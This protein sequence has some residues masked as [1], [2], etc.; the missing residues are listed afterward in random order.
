MNAPGVD[1][2]AI[3]GEVVDLAGVRFRQAGDFTAYE[4]IDNIREE[5]G[6]NLSEP[7]AR[8]KLLALVRAGVLETELRIDPDIKRQV[9]VYWRTG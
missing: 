1:L 5:R 6:G 4:F 2:E 7:T 8:K 3:L 9:R